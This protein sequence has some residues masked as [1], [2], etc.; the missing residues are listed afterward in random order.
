MLYFQQQ[1]ANF[2]ICCL[3]GNMLYVYPS[4]FFNF[5][6]TVLVTTE[7][8]VTGLV[9]SLESK[10]TSIHNF[11]QSKLRKNNQILMFPGD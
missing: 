11:F 5:L 9:G 4:P 2:A 7:K 3:L 6:K 10:P 8:D 1:I